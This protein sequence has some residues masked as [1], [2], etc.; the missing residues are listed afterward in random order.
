[1]QAAYH[2]EI[3]KTKDASAARTVDLKEQIE[4]KEKQV[5]EKKVEYEKAIA[6]AQKLTEA[7]TEKTKAEE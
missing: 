6:E 2:L 7:T 5:A 3:Q 4:K 1:M